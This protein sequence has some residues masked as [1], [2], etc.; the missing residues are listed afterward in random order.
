MSILTVVMRIC[1]EYSYGM[2][3]SNYP[4]VGRDPEID[5]ERYTVHVNGRDI[6]DY[7]KLKQDD[8]ELYKK[9]LDHEH[10][11]DEQEPGLDV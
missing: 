5:L 11:V 4:V 1:F 9:V 6:I 2:S 10:E 7:E 3:S 8:S